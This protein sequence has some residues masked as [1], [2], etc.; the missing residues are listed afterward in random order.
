MGKSYKN[1][2]M[3]RSTGLEPVPLSDAPLKRARMPIPPRSHVAFRN[4]KYYSRFSTHLSTD[5]L[6]FLWNT[7][8]IVQYPPALR[9]ETMD[10]ACLCDRLDKQHHRTA[11]FVFHPRYVHHLLRRLRLL[12]TLKL[13]TL[14]Q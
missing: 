13:E 7:Y 14:I 1:L 9:G 11:Q 3:V 2:P 8:F 4:G 10:L 6:K 12:H 5:F